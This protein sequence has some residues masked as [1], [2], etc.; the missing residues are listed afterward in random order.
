[1]GAAAEP[2][3]GRNVL[4]VLC[5]LKE[6][7]K[8]LLRALGALAEAPPSALV[9]SGWLDP[10]NVKARGVS[11]GIAAERLSRGNAGLGAAKRGRWAGTTH[12]ALSFWTSQGSSPV[13]P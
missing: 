3:D 12:L 9:R 5:M 13:T 7:L 2:A 6:L 8:V 1:V 4:K 11:C 10:T